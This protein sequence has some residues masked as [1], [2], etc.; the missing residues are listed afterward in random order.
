MKWNG[1]KWNKE[2]LTEDGYL[3]KIRF[4]EKLNS[5]WWGAFFQGKEIAVSTS[6]KDLKRTLSA[7]QKA[8]QQRMIRHLKTKMTG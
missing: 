7:A 4:V 3:L 5:Y 2:M 8:V 1:D 6:K